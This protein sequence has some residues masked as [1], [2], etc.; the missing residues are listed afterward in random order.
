MAISFERADNLNRA[1]RALTLGS[2]AR[3]ASRLADLGLHP[4]QEVLLLQLARG[5]AA[6]QAQ[7]ADA[8]G[9]EPPSVTLMVN[10]LADAGHVRRRPSPTDRRL[11]IIELTESG[12]ALI[13]P[14]KQLWRGLADE[15]VGD[16]TPDQ[17]DQA[18]N[19]LRTLADNITSAKSRT[20]ASQR[21]DA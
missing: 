14:L 16:L 21:R 18:T 7:L 17:I 5:G 6:H 4:G 1:I 19:L 10:K 3:A 13:K 8:I 12:A 20:Q 9:I 11:S 2:R 15:T